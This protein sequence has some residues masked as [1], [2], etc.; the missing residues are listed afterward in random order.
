MAA[1]EKS[2]YSRHAGK[3]LCGAA[4]QGAETELIHLYDLKYTGCTSC[5]AC[6]IIGGKSYGK[7]AVNDDLLPVLRRIEEADAL[8]LGSPVFLALSPVKCAPFERL[9]SNTCATIGS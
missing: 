3:S 6:K 2:E 5:F 8:I 9:Y 7:C 1:P 4:D